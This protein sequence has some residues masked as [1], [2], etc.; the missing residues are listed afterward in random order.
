LAGATEKDLDAF[1]SEINNYINESLNRMEKEGSKRYLNY[2]R[3]GPGV[4]VEVS[5]DSIVRT[6]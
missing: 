5:E 3:R 4:T 2:H 6:N 1:L